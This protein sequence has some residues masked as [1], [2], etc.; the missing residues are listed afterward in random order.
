MKNKILT[1]FVALFGIVLFFWLMVTI[2][3]TGPQYK[4]VN[5]VVY[6]NY[7]TGDVWVKIKKE[8]VEIK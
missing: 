3:N 6:E 5:G 4:C 1:V 8:C 2:A 7:M